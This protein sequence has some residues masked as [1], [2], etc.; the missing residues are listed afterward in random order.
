MCF[1]INVGDVLVT[2][3]CINVGDVF[4]I[5]LYHCRWCFLQI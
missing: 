4:N 5:F 3:F 2:Y 1:C